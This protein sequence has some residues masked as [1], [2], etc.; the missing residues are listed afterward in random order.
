MLVQFSSSFRFTRFPEANGKEPG[1][2]GTEQGSSVPPCGELTEPGSGREINGS[3]NEKLRLW[4][5]SQAQDQAHFRT[6][7]N[8]QREWSASQIPHQHQYW[9]VGN[10]P[11]IRGRLSRRNGAMWQV[12]H[13]SWQGHG[14][15]GELLACACLHTHIL[16]HTYTHTHK[17][18]RDMRSRR[19][20]GPTLT[21]APGL[22]ES[23]GCLAFI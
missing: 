20:W 23:W 15:C 21:P 22:D 3:P 8:Y 17:R 4:V 1:S 16:G 9:K 6:G 5:T 7:R 2:C 10:H 11:H 12:K 14:M 19:R 13:S 18:E